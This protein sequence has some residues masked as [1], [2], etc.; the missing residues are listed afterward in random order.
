VVTATVPPIGR[1]SRRIVF[2]VASILVLVAATTWWLTQADERRINAACD[3]YLEHRGL[4]RSALSETDEALGRAVD[5][6][7]D[8]LEDQHFNDA[9]AV[10]SWIDQWLREGPDVIDSLDD[11]RDTIQSLTD[12]EDGLVELQ[13]LIEQS[14]PSELANWLPE[15]GARMQNF[16]DTCLWAARSTWL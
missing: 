15:V 10:R 7:A 11:D 4:L 8:R 16:D 1:R 2:A 3:T 12:I 6:K 13:S 9:D 14:E 5:A